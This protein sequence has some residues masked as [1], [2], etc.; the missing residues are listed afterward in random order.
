MDQPVPAESQPFAESHSSIGLGS[1]TGG[2]VKAARRLDCRV[3]NHLRYEHVVC[4]PS[5][6]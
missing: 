3:G 4:L 1:R 6:L 2:D 5:V